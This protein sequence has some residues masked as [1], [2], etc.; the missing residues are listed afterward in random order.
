MIQIL[1][2]IYCII[3][4]NFESGA[5][6]E[7]VPEHEQQHDAGGGVA[8]HRP[9]EHGGVLAEIDLQHAHGHN[10]HAVGHDDGHL[11][12]QHFGSVVEA[13][14]ARAQHPFIIEVRGQFVSGG[15]QR[16]EHQRGEGPFE[17]VLQRESQCGQRQ[18]QEELQQEQRAAVVSGAEDVR[19]HPRLRHPGQKQQGGQ[20]GGDG[21]THPHLQEHQQGH[22][23][24]HCRILTRSARLCSTLR[25]VL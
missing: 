14:H 19:P 1:L 5:E 12:G 24:G 13:L 6:R 7:R 17:A 11:R 15:E 10:H 21:G 3:P 2:L 20:K 4:R 23:G 16:D 22:E 18:R 8:A 9:G 25:G